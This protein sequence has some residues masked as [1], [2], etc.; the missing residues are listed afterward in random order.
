MTPEYLLALVPARCMRYRLKRPLDYISYDCRTLKFI[1]S[2]FP[3]VISDWTNLDNSLLESATYTSFKNQVIR[4]VRPLRKS[5]YNIHHPESFRFFT[6]LRLGLSALR[7][8]KFL[9]K[10]ADVKDQNCLISYDC[11]EDTTHFL[12]ECKV[13]ATHRTTLLDTVSN[14]LGF[15]VSCVCADALCTILLYGHRERDS[16]VNGKVLF[17]TIKF[18]VDTKRFS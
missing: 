5:T 17:A 7:A 12:L 18:I 8:H 2:F 1:A 10:F 16:A 9:H 3:A 14:L 4:I 6:Q 15:S 11:V 13:F